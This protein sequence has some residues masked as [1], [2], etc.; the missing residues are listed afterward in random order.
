MELQ[1]EESDE[2]LVADEETYKTFM[3]SIWPS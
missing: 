3:L 1:P 2:I